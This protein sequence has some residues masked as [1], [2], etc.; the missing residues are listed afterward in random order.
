MPDG[1]FIGGVEVGEQHTI[2][3]TFTISKTAN[4]LD[5]LVADI[6]ATVA[7]SPALRPTLDQEVAYIENGVTLFG[8]LIT[9][10]R[11]HELTG[12]ATDDFVTEITA[13]DYRVF[14]KRRY[15]TATIPAGTLKSFLE[16]LVDYLTPYGV[17]LDPS[18]VDGP[19]LQATT[20]SFALLQ[21]VFDG[22]ATAT[23]GAGDPFAWR[24]NG[25]KVLSFIQATAAPFDLA[26]GD[27]R[28]LGDIEVE[29][30]RAENYAN[31]VTVVNTNLSM[32]VI[33]ADFV[34][35]GVATS[36]TTEH[37]ADASYFPGEVLI[38]GVT[39]P[40][41]LAP[42]L[43]L[44]FYTWDPTTHTLAQR[45]GDPPLTAGTTIHLL[46]GALVVNALGRVDTFTGDGVT[47]VF[48]LTADVITPRVTVV[49]DGAAEPIGAYPD[50]S[51]VLDTTVH[52]PTLTRTSPP[53]NGAV[54]TYTYDGFVVGTAT[55]ED[56][57][58]IAAHGLYEA[59][60]QT[61]STTFVDAL[62]TAILAER[63]AS[64]R[65]IRFAT[66]ETGLDVLQGMHVTS[67][68]RNLDT[69]IL[70]S[71]LTIRYEPGQA[72][73][74]AGGALRR[75]IVGIASA[76]PKPNWRDTYV[77][78]AGGSTRGSADGGGVPTGVSTPTIAPAATVEPLGDTEA[79]GTAS[80]YSRGDHRHA[81]AILSADPTSPADDTFW[82]RKTGTT[83]TMSV[84]LR[85]RIDGSTETLAGVTR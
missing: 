74:G 46:Y 24:I 15:V 27:T 12:V 80:T 67:G 60:V 4:G 62:A 70:I 64:A 55:A 26:D 16:I 23:A 30:V 85:Y 84:E 28:L 48:V 32:T 31:R 14:A 25:D 18:Q 13:S 37:D 5:T 7:A 78:W 45:G 2:L 52:P 66:F 58:E 82:L 34:A 65:T 19:D 79:A 40:I 42:G 43:G 76:V 83:P 17:T 8:G 36:W 33:P 41:E 72:P 49:V 68:K 38:D 22:L 51:W 77:Q 50:P 20:Y 29:E 53:A 54:I 3:D 47:A 1:L 11:E 35:D 57:A 69:D 9:G 21:D 63:K 59:V 73:V 75:E 56:A 6:D 39:Y 10:V 44:F 71:E 81:L 61:S